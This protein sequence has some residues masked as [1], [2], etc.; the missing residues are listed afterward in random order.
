MKLDSI[1][2]VMSNL[3]GKASSARN[4]LHDIYTYRTN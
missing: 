2:S 4:R 3:I 1:A